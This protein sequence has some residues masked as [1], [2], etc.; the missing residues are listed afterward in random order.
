M[1]SCCYTLDKAP[2]TI[3]CHHNLSN[4]IINGHLVAIFMYIITYTVINSC[5]MILNTAYRYL[6]LITVAIAKGKG[7]WREEGKGKRGCII[8]YAIKCDCL[9]CMISC[10]L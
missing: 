9:F 6:F 7:R 3:L 5:C 10:V 4:Y 1:D 8:Q 2:F